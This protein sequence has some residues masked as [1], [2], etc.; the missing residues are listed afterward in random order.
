MF[1]KHGNERNFER[2]IR[3]RRQLSWIYKERVLYK[4]EIVPNKNAKG[5]INEFRVILYRFVTF[6]VGRYVVINY[7]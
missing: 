1:L 6:L 2:F 5:L 3:Q 4:E 7:K